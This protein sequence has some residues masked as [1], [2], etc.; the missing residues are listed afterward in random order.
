MAKIL[1]IE[2]DVFVQRFLGVVLANLKHE[3]IMTDNG[4]QA[5][6]LAKDE[7]IG[8]ILSD[9]TLPGA[10]SGMEMVG[11]LRAARPACPIVV[12][13]GFPTEENMEEC[14]AL[15]IIDF[16]TKPFEIGFILSTIQ[17]I[18]PDPPSTPP[19]PKSP[20]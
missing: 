13:S 6:E 9:L 5:V 17:R 2:D 1:I 20:P 16:L 11:K 10:L 7:T 19:T 18:L 14:K 8:L 4:I 12:V 15:G 3:I